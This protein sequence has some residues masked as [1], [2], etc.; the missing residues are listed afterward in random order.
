MVLS[1]IPFP[2]IHQVSKQIS[3]PGSFILG[4][5]W[6][7][8]GVNRTFLGDLYTR[9]WTM[10][11][12]SPGEN[13]HRE[14]TFYQD[15]ELWESYVPEN[16]SLGVPGDW[17]S[18]RCGKMWSEWLLEIKILRTLLCHAKGKY[19]AFFSSF[20]KVPGWDLREETRKTKL[21]STISH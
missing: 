15:T 18:E 12:I 17:V 2:V 1:P 10:N 8:M 19:L 20:E 14:G 11:A 6:G 5:G 21:G 3:S 13:G 7:R 9:P 16:N 4:S